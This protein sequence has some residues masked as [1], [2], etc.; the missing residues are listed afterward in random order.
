MSKFLLIGPPKIGKSVAANRIANALGCTSIKYEWDSI[1]ELP[2]NALA[3]GTLNVDLS[4][5]DTSTVVFLADSSGALQA[6]VEGLEHRP[7][8][9]K[10]FSIAKQLAETASWLDSAKINMPTD[11]RL[12]AA[13]FVE[14][15]HESAEH[16]SGN[17]KAEIY[18][19]D[20]SYLNHD[21]CAHHPV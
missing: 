14:A 1:N 17:R 5:V 10:Q 13:G 6:L 7:I 16:L 11:W 9:P 12:D 19:P 8:T 15:L 2:D 21:T 20:D 18:S 4:R 3:V